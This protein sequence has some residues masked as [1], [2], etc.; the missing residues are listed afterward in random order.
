MPLST[1]ATGPSA[2]NGLKR[3][4]GRDADPSARGLEQGAFLR[5]PGA[6]WRN[7]Q[8]V[9]NGIQNLRDRA[10][11]M[12]TARHQKSRKSAVFLS[13]MRRDGFAAMRCGRGGGGGGGSVGGDGEGRGS[14][15]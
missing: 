5:Y 2:S 13:S 14:R 3:F 15:T 10:F 9:A 7:V 12:Y 4:A 8:P 1:L 11:V 6:G